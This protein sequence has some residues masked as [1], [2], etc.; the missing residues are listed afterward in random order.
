METKTVNTY[1]RFCHAYCP[2]VARVEG[3]RLVA[4]EPD[5]DNETYGG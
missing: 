3:N 4:L 1:C 2:M 5:T